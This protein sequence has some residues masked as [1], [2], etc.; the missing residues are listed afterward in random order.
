MKIKL[1]WL[2]QAQVLKKIIIFLISIQ[3]SNAQDLIFK[4]NGEVIE[5]ADSITKCNFFIGYKISEKNSLGSIKFKRF[6]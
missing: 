3:F 6:L 2:N 4:N 5:G 1:Q